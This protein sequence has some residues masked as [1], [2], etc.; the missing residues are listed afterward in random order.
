MLR[1]ILWQCLLMSAIL[2]AFALPAFGAESASLEYRIDALQIENKDFP[3]PPPW[4]R[5]D[6]ELE[7]IVTGFNPALYDLIIEIERIP[8]TMQTAAG[9]SIWLPGGA[10]APLVKMNE[11][12]TLEKLY[13]AWDDEFGGSPSKFILD[14]IVRAQKEYLGGGA[15]PPS[16]KIMDEVTKVVSYL[17][18]Q[19]GVDIDAG[20]E[21]N[22]QLVIGIERQLDVFKD[23]DV[24]KPATDENRE[25]YRSELAKIKRII[26]A[27]T[28]LGFEASQTIKM[29]R[30][31]DLE[32]TVVLKPRQHFNDGE[33]VETLPLGTY[34]LPELSTGP[35]LIRLEGA[36]RQRLSS[37][38]F[39]TQARDQ[40]FRLELQADKPE[41]EDTN[42][43]GYKI[44]EGANSSINF[45][46]GALYHY[47]LSEQFG[48]DDFDFSMGI[49]TNGQKLL[50]FGGLSYRFGSDDS[51]G[52]LSFGMAASQV[53]VLD[54]MDF[55]KIYADATDIKT[56]TVFKLEPCLS[57]SLLF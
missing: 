20:P 41:T 29:E 42:E 31:Y 7:I 25:R 8:V 35:M 28:K 9:T 21:V 49:G 12:G 40:A 37:A 17:A 34:E 23:Y 38:V 45:Y 5:E 54:N 39:F 44:V 18:V 15:N 27:V 19:A 14:A 43:A 53:D 22:E 50:Y 30:S 52:Y 13:D 2:F 10:G 1:T 4:L 16:S 33:D 46:V 26:K 51:P 32:I 56:R 11:V 36:T 6:D 47:D 24:S 3:L 55:N 48:W 57:L